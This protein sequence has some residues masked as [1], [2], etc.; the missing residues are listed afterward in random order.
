MDEYGYWLM[1]CP[2]GW[3]ISTQKYD[4][5]EVARWHQWQYE[6]VCAI[7]AWKKARAFALRYLGADTE[8]V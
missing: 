4:F 5:E 1:V 8:A 7:P 3:I 2:Y 6:P